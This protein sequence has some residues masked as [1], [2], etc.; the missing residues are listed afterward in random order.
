M[1][2]SSSCI[3]KGG[4]RAPKDAYLPTSALPSVR[5]PLINKGSPPPPDKT[6]QRRTSGTIRW[7][8]HNHIDRK[9]ATTLDQG[10]ITIRVDGW[11]NSLNPK[12]LRRMAGPYVLYPVPHGMDGPSAGPRPREALLRTAQPTCLVPTAT[13]PTRP[14]PRYLLWHGTGCQGSVRDGAGHTDPSHPPKPNPT[15]GDGSA[16]TRRQQATT[17]TGR[18]RGTESPSHRPQRPRPQTGCCYTSQ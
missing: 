16:S 4:L 12:K 14:N 18:T 3:V 7:A 11:L 2:R 10:Y 9:Q 1:R 6:T 17:P 5:M 13:P 8:L 15:H